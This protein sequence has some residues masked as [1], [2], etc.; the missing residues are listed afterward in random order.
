LRCIVNLQKGYT[1]KILFEGK[2]LKKFSRYDQAKNI[3]F[4]FQDFNLFN[5]LTAFENCM[6]PMINL[7]KMPVNEAREKT[8]TLLEKFEIDSFKNLYPFK[9]SHGQK[10]KV[11]I[12][13]ALVGNPK[14]LI[15][16]EPTASLDSESSE[17]LAKL[18]LELS[19]Q[20]IA[21]A[22]TSHDLPFLNLIIDRV[23][24]IEEGEITDFDDKFNNKE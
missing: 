12:A 5:N 3:G 8:L 18:L 6:F 9:L 4:V 1:G 13:R 24:Y 2:N 22:L 11:A 19:S 16:D 14:V 10:Q 15:L 23:Y 7:L 20:G 21:V 17:K